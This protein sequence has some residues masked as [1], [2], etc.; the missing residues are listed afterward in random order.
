MD[1]IDQSYLKNAESKQQAVTMTRF[2][3]K[4]K[5]EKK[6]GS[7]N[8]NSLHF[9]QQKMSHIKENLC[10]IYQTGKHMH[11]PELNKIGHKNRI[12]SPSPDRKS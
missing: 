2:Y 10:R 3:Q 1:R 11:L 7:G 5:S 4:Q 6:D 8:H 9:P 12:K